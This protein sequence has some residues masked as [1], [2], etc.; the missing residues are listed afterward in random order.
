MIRALTY[1]RVKPYILPVL[2]SL[3]AFFA[4]EG[5]F[6][7][8]AERSLGSIV[9]HNVGTIAVLA[10][11]FLVCNE[12]IIPAIF[13]LKRTGLPSINQAAPL[14]LFAVVAG[15]TVS[16]YGGLDII[17]GGI[18]FFIV[19]CLGLSVFFIFSEK[20]FHAFCLFWCMYPFLYFIQTQGGSIGFERPVI[21]DD[22][23]VPFSSVYISILFCASILANLKKGTLFKDSNLRF[24]Y[25]FILLSIPSMFYSQNPMKSTAYFAFDII[26]PVMY[27]I[28][29]LSA[30]KTRQQIESAVK[31]ILLSL[32]II[33][34]ITI[35]FY[36]RSGQAE[37]ALDLSAAEGAMIPF[38]TLASFAAVMFPMFFMFYKI[39]RNKIYPFLLFAFAML[40]VLS[41]NRNSMLVLLFSCLLLFLFSKI[42]VSKKVFIV[43]V[44]LVCLFFAFFL[45]HALGIGV[46]IRHRLFFTISQLRE[47]V[48]IN[49]ISS[50]RWEIWES[51]V[52]MIKDHP[53]MGIG[54]G[55]WQDNAF[56]YQS[57]EYMSNLPGRGYFFYSAVDAHNFF[58]DLYLK[59]GVLPVLLF[60]YF[61]LNM[62][63]KCSA[64]YKK[65]TDSN[66]KRLIIASFIS[67][68]VWIV[69]SIFE[70]RLY[71]YW[72]GTVLPG[73]FFWTLTV[74]VF[75]SVDTQAKQIEAV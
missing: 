5:I 26:V 68:L 35:Y 3:L 13:D 6:K 17:Y 57:R 28:F 38:A 64:A 48:D 59:Y 75:K 21:F 40:V 65:E 41:D 55:M 39:T 9:R 74:F 33:S 69:L 67:L 4:G 22:L 7:I 58:L 34:S 18:I 36:M 14:A 61:L 37:G 27:F 53:I 46:E 63:K 29:A 54:A 52:R 10:I 32:L 31:F 62:L 72:L 23:V 25:W 1:D 73:I 51:A 49:E 24:I 43:S 44:G 60:S 66:A 47:G 2:I 45:S 20:P 70:Y 56:L 30:I 8:M 71:I 42:A 19:L 12:G 16:V 11:I 15:I 50:G